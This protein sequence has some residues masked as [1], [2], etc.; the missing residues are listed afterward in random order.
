MFDGEYLNDSRWNGK[1]KEYKTF[2]NE[3]KILL[4]EGHYINGQKYGKEYD[5]EGKFIF[6]GE[7]FNENIWN[8]KGKEYNKFD[9]LIFE[10]EYKNGKRWKGKEY[11][12]YKLIYE[13]E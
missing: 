3:S 4:F 11:E 1:L 8:G 2:N 9:E 10:G 12:N 7:F 6:E 13:G 5:Y